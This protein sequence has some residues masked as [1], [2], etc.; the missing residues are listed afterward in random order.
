MNYFTYFLL[1]FRK[2]DVFTVRIFCLKEAWRLNNKYGVDKRKWE[3]KKS[4]IKGKK[5]KNKKGKKIIMRRG[6]TAC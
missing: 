5:E 6:E 3:R 1:V 2:S 4:R